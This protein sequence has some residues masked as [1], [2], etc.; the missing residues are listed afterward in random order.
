MAAEASVSSPIGTPVPRVEGKEKVTGQA[1]YTADYT[2]PGMLWGAILHS[3]IP[4]GRIVRIDTSKARAVPG[5]HAVLTGQDIGE[6]RFGRALADI[7]VL[8]YDRVRYVGEPLVAVAAEGR[9]VAKEAVA[10]IEVEYEEL[11]AVFDPFEAMKPEAPL[12]HPQLAEYR[13]GGQKRGSNAA[14]ADGHFHVLETRGRNV[15]SYELESKGDVEQGFRE[16]DL[17]L[18]HTYRTSIIHQSYIEPHTCLVSAEPDGKARIWASNKSPFTIRDYLAIDLDLPDKDII[19][20]PTWVG[21][22]YGGKGSPLPIPIAYFLSK[23][24]GRPVKVV[25]DLAAEFIAANPRHATWITIRSGLKRDGRIVAREVKMVA[26]S[27]AY[28]GYKPI[29]GAVIVGSHN[30]LGVY[31]TPHARFECSIVYTNHVPAGHMRSPGSYQSAWACEADIDRL[32]EAVGMDPIE[33]RLLN[34]VEEGDEGPLGE[35]WSSVHLKD[36][37]EAVRAA[38]GWDQ[39]KPPNVG[40]GVALAQDRTGSGASTAQVEVDANGRVTLRTT[41]MDQGAGMLTVLAQIVAHELQLPVE[42]VNVE[43]MSTQAELY[44][45]GSSA[46]SVTHAAGQAALGAVVAAREKLAAVACEMFDCQPEEVELA[47]GVFRGP[48]HPLPPD[49]EGSGRGVSLAE[50]AGRA[51]VGGEPVVGHCRYDG[52]KRHYG[53]AFSAQVAEVEVDPRTGQVKVRRIVNAADVGTLLNPIGATGQ[54][55][56]ATIVA[57]GHTTMEELRLA[58]G[59]VQNTSL[60]E[61][62][63]PTSGDLPAIENILIHGHGGGPGPYGSKTVADLALIVGPAAITNAIHDAIGERFDELPITAEKVYRALKAREVTS[64]A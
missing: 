23:A 58:D 2:L 48:P 33:F 37:L 26:D 16:A 38:S 12:L 6:V 19:F 17:V 14:D 61:Y 64:E 32:A 24:S 13:W 44:D 39:P 18:E 15:V 30:A 51:C 34:G 60:R 21:G 3:T 35:P 53:A 52:W 47:D 55:E 36:C 41:V 45:W 40:R 22:D 63:V 50:V 56:G 25:W 28:A 54:M 5:V 9:D 11:A 7:P 4:H 43:V 8:A 29:P 27:G 46:L 62:K 20:E 57:L 59:R 31:K 10:L 42:S 49:G 1:K